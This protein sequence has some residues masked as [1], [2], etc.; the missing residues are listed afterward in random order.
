MQQKTIRLL[1]KIQLSLW[2][3]VTLAAELRYGITNVFLKS[4]DKMTF[5]VLSCPF[6]IIIKI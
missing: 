4:Y 3:L 5:Y 2:S 6:L 1:N